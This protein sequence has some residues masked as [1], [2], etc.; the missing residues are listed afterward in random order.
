MSSVSEKRKTKKVDSED[1][2]IKD[3]TTS[4]TSIAAGLKQVFERNVEGTALKGLPKAY[5]ARTVF[6]RGLWIAALLIGAVSGVIQVVILLRQFLSY[7]TTIA[8]VDSDEP[9]LF[10]AISICNANPLTM[11]FDIDPDYSDLS[12][13]IYRDI[14]PVLIPSFTIETLNDLSSLTEY[15]R[16]V[17]ELFSSGT[18][19]QSLS[20][21]DRLYLQNYTKSTIVQDCTW[22]PWVDET[23]TSQLW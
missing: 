1:D 14:L 3:V 20:A 7:E 9:S 15:E 6:Q 23:S 8:T 2:D 5:K 10:P 18:Y 22:K 17:I 12:L 16:S 19:F 11:Q 13:E 4:K 21:E